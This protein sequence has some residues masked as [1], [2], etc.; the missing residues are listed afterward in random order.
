MNL[1]LTLLNKSLI[2]YVSNNKITGGDNFMEEHRVL[3]DKSPD[4]IK[5]IERSLS[6]ALGDD[7][8]IDIKINELDTGNS[9]PD[10]IWDFINRNIGKNFPDEQYI[11]KPTKRGRWELKPIF[12]KSTGILYTLMREERLEE[13]RKE[14]T[15]R[16]SMHYAQALAEALN[17]DLIPKQEQLSFLQQQNYYDEEKVKQI[18]HKI[19]DDLSIPDNIVKRHALILFRSNNY[20]LT[21]LRCCIVKSDLSIVEE[22]DWNSYIEANESAVAEL[23][24]TEPS[25]INPTNG[26]KFKQKAKDRIDQGELGNVK[27]EMEKDS[28]RNE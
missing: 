18:V 9:I 16:K 23:T 26:L 17:K 13:L 8:K 21:S 10:R 4:F 22:A 27:K 25:Y 19:F 14:V 15:K 11:A 20:E 5:R 2:L 1:Q 24:V 12:E 7:I 3:I 28:K 6:D